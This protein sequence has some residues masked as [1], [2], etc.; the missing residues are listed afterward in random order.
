MMLGHGLLLPEFG[1][2]D[3]F[4]YSVEGP[5]RVSAFY[6]RNP[7]FWMHENMYKVFV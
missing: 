4:S 5:T 3:P 2:Q 1:V 7:E 6:M